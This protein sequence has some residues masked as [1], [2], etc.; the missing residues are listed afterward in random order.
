MRRSTWKKLRLSQDVG[1]ELRVL[2]E[3]RAKVAFDKALKV[4]D[5]VVGSRKETR[6]M[7]LIVHHVLDVILGKPQAL[8]SVSTAIPG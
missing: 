2:I 6:P 3:A 5:G 7:E 4:D 1:L 8:L